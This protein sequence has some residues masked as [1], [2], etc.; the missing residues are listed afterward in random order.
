MIPTRTSTLFG[1][2][3]PATYIAAWYGVTTLLLF[4]LGALRDPFPF[5]K[6]TPEMA[7]GLALL[8]SAHLGSGAVLLF[9]RYRKAEP[10]LAAALVI[11]TAVF[12]LAFIVLFGFRLY[13]SRIVAIGF[14]IAALVASVVPRLVRRSH[15]IYAGSVAATSAFL[16]LGA[17]FVKTEPA[18]PPSGPQATLL[19]TSMYG[20]R[21][22]TYPD[23]IEKPPLDGGGIAAFGDRFLLATGDGRLYVLDHRNGALDVTRVAGEVPINIASFRSTVSNDTVEVSYF[24]VTDVLVQ[25]VSPRVVRIFASH[26]FWKEDARCFV[27]RV[28]MVEGD[29]AALWPADDLVW[30]TVF[31]STPCLPIKARWQPFAANS[32]GRM[33]LLDENTLLVTVGDFEFD[34]V[35]AAANYPQDMSASYGKTIEIDL[36]SRANRVFSMGHRNAQGLI[37]TSEGAIWS[38]EHGPYGGDELNRIVR[39]ENYGWPTVTYGTNYSARGWPLNPSQ[40]RHDSFRPPV[41]AWIPSVGLSSLLEVRGEKFEKWQGDLLIGSLNGQTLFRVRVSADQALFAEP[42]RYGA[43]IRDLEIG[44]DGSIAV[45][46]DP[47]EVAFLEPAEER[48]IEGEV[49]FWTACGA[50]HVVR[51]GLRHGIGP[52]L[53]GIMTR[54]VASAKGFTYSKTLSHLGGQWTDERLDAFLASPEAVAPDTHMRDV[55]V[56]DPKTRADLIEYLKTLR[57]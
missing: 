21:V 55:S 12:G 43:R 16:A 44:G 51:D 27:M 7:V 31:E 33:A 11:T 53:H 26:H 4:A 45:W 50:C 34:G 18:P 30:T 5:W 1:P 35:N 25:Q 2:R 56:T 48:G 37:V 19:A 17:S 38:A 28:S 32:G 20:V 13:S 14:F 6:L 3:F 23:A 24:R 54:D 57:D 46:A 40:G 9:L 15:L 41:F 36:T 22:V 42:I 8:A 49:A 29:P 52:D 47:G 10:T 39:G